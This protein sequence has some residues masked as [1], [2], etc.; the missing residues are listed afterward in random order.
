MGPL[1]SELEDLVT[2]D[3]EKDAVLN[4]TF[5]SV[6]TSK[7]RLQESQV[8]EIRRNAGTRQCTLGGKGSGQGILRQTGHT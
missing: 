7:T 1:L 6:F 3:M 5:A 8:P 2:H 4:D